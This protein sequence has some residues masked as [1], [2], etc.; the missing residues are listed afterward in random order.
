MRIDMPCCSIKTCKY[1]SDGNCT[2]VGRYTQYDYS[3]L[4]LFLSGLKE[5]LEKL[6][7]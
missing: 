3:H 6:G 2:S 4:V 1:W 5:Q 7:V